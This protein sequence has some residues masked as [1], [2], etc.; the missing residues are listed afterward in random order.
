VGRFRLRWSTG[1]FQHHAIVGRQSSLTRDRDNEAVS[2]AFAVHLFC[3]GIAEPCPRLCSLFPTPATWFGAL[4][5]KHHV[6]YFTHDGCRLSTVDCR[7]ASH[8]IRAG[9]GQGVGFVSNAISQEHQP[10]NQSDVHGRTSVPTLSQR[11]DK[12][13]KT[14]QRKR[15][16]EGKHEAKSNKTVQHPSSRF[17]AAGL[18]YRD[19]SH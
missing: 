18:S 12:P 13:E 7:Q 10:T 9:V 1:R 6:S 8:Y 14:S 19:R 11:K 2:P 5:P 15:Q 16:V 17:A 4:I 3:P